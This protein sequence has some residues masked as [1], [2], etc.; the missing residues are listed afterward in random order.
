MPAPH[1]VVRPRL[2]VLGS[3][4]AH[5]KSPSLHA[6]AYRALGVD[7]DYGRHE[8]DEPRL[9]PW[10]AERGVGWRGA[11][12][13]MPLKS[14]V[15]ALCRSIS[16]TARVAGAVNTIVFAGPEAD[17]PFDGHN[18]DV[19]GVRRALEEV[20][21]QPG[22]V[23]LLGSGNTASSVVLACAEAGSRE[24]VVRAR[25]RERAAETMALA[26][27]L[28]MRARAVPLDAPG[29]G[30]G[31]AIVVNT[32]PGGET[33]RVPVDAAVRREAVLLEVLYDPW[34]TALAAQWFEVGGRVASG[35]DMLVHQALAQVRLFVRGDDGA[36]DVDDATLL[37]AMRAAVA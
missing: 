16:E 31:A 2:A 18:T 3:P 36:R 1:G 13:T 27:R 17:A 12:L 6:A 11:S 34:P 5:S 24:L 14:E 7:F 10:L 29:A 15:I 26:Q 30:E 33:L 32:I 35:L 37:R 22:P 25:S 4:I 20:R 8:V 28:G 21:A 23:E 19:G 9:A